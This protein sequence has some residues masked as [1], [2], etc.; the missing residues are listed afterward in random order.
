LCRYS[1]GGQQNSF[2]LGPLS[3]NIKKREREREKDVRYTA[4]PFSILSKEARANL[5][6]YILNEKVIFQVKKRERRKKEKENRK[7]HGRKG[8]MHYLVVCDK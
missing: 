4:G 2:Y 3:R 6:I 7:K 1:L 5:A 8:Q